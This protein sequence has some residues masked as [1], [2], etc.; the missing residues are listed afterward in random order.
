MHQ[1]VK[2]V[3]ILGEAAPMEKCGCMSCGKVGLRRGW[4]CWTWLGRGHGVVS[5][6]IWFDP[7]MS[8]KS[9]SMDHLVVDWPGKDEA[10]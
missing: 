9:Q 6:T 7:Y 4:E 5:V 10:R 8:C 2:T 3:A 1:C